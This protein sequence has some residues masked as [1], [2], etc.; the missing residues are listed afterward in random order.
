VGIG[1]NIAPRA[2]QDLSTPPAALRE[3]WPEAE[4]GLCLQRIAL[5]LVRALRDFERFGF[6]PFQARF[7]ARDVLRDRDIA[8]SDGTMGTSLGVTAQGALLVHTAAGMT[9]V[10]SSEVSVRPRTGPDGARP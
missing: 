7:E 10:T 2:A 6:A 5:P 9:T 8:L 4:P 1:I 3:L